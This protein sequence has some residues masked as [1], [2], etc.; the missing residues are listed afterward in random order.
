MPLPIETQRLAIRPFKPEDA[1]AMFEVWSDPQVMKH[2]PREPARSVADVK[3]RLDRLGRFH[4]DQG[5]SI[6]GVCL[7][8]PTEERLF[9]VPV[10]AAG[11]R[12]VAWTGP[13]IELHVELAR[14]LWGNGLGSEAAE[15][16]L[17]FG[18]TELGL[19]AIIGL[20]REQNLRGQRVLDK[21]Q[22][23]YEGP[24]NAYYGIELV[25]FIADR[26]S[27]G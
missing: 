20:V 14:E 12:P 3:A 22:M 26:E 13:E 1:D 18:F 7:R 6:W 15:A 17:A 19:D 21:L 5:M 16:V 8:E 23:R 24:T 10:G 25:K 9:D 4:R 27:R 2:L 11:L